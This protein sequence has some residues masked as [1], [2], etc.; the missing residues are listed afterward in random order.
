[1]IVVV[2]CEHHDEAQQD[3]FVVGHRDHVAV[4][5]GAE[6][7]GCGGGGRVVERGGGGGDG[8]KGDG[9][10]GGGEGWW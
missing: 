4:S 7:E 8:V 1:M 9:V 2:T 5:R 10:K 3:A 6:G